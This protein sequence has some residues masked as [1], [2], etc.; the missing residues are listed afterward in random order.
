MPTGKFESDIAASPEPSKFA[1]PKIVAPLW[2]V[3]VPVGTAL[4][5]AG[6]TVAVNVTDAPNAIGLADATMVDVV[7]IAACVTFTDVAVGVALAAKLL[8]PP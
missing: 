4:P 7:A 2:N 5:E 1:E 8:D 6:F 3:T